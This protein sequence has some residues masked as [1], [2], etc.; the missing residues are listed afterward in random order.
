MESINLRSMLTISNEFGL[1]CG[2]SDHT[3]GNEVSLA[4]VAMGATTIE[5]HFTLDK[6]AVGPDHAASI[7][8]DELKLLVVSIRN[9]EKAMGTFVSIRRK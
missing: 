9:V 4:A 6:L 1:P 8:P 3:V 5:K 2:Y 7:T